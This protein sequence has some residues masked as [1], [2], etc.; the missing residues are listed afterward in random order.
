MS[1]ITVDGKDVDTKLLEELKENIKTNNDIV[2]RRNTLLVRYT[3][4]LVALTILMSVLVLGQ[5]ILMF[6]K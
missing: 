6:V 3:G 1:E 2:G 4:Y 5:L